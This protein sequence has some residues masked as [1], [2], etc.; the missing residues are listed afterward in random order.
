MKFGERG[1][2]KHI[3]CHR[4]KTINVDFVFQLQNNQMNRNCLKCQHGDT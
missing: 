1:Y 3:L 2:C 4:V